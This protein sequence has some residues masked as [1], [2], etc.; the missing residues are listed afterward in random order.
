MAFGMAREGNESEST[1]GHEQ[2]LSEV[3][4]AE[5]QEIAHRKTVSLSSVKPGFK[6][7]LGVRQG[8]KLKPSTRF[9]LLGLALSGG[10]IRSATF[11][12]GVLQ[13]LSSRGILKHVDYLST[14][15]GG[16]YLGSCLSSLLNSPHTEP[17]GD[18]FP[19]R[20][21]PGVEEPKAVK[22]LRNH[23]NYLSSGGLLDTIR[24]PVLLLRGV[25]INLLAVLPYV[26]LT[27]IL[28]GYIYGKPMVKEFDKGKVQLKAAHH[29]EGA[30]SQAVPKND[31]GTNK[32]T[33]FGWK[34]S[35]VV[36]KILCIG[37]FLWLLLFPLVCWLYTILPIDRL[38]G[39]GWNARDWYERSFAFG[40]AVI[41][42]AAI[43][44]SLP[45]AIVSY[46][47]LWEKVR[48]GPKFFQPEIIT[49]TTIVTALLPFLFSGHALSQIS[50]W[51]RTL[52]LYSL[53]LLGPLIFFLLYLRLGAWLIL[54]QSPPYLGD[55]NLELAYFSSK[56]H[57]AV[58][59]L[60]LYNWQFID[61]NLT[62]LHRFY[63]DRLSKAYLFRVDA[64]GEIRPNDDQK[65]STLNTEGTKAPYHLINAAIN[66]QGSQDIN[67]RGRHSAFF[68]FSKHFTGSEKT[69]YCQTHL[70][71]RADPRI[72][73][74]TT[75]AISGAA[76]APNMG[77]ATVKSL[78][79]ILT[80]LNIRLGYWL[81]NPRR[82]SGVLARLLW[83]R[84]GPLY[85]LKELFSNLD[86]HSWH[87]NIS[88][89]GHIENM[90]VYQL[91]RRHCKFIIIGDAEQDSAL[92]FGGLATL[93]RLARIDMGI[94]IEM[95]LSK[96][97][98]SA[99][100][101]SG[102]HCALGTIHYGNG[103]TGQL[104]YLKSSLTGDEKEYLR[105]YR[106]RHPTFPHESTT[107]QFFDE[108]QFEVYRALGY[109][110]ANSLFKG[111]KRGQTIDGG[112]KTQ[113]GKN[114]VERW[115]DSLNTILLPT[116][117]K[118]AATSRG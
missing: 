50:G 44:E 71:E 74:G 116:P 26:I 64:Q 105:A 35:Y 34:Q 82:V 29:Q 23:S 112:Q 32:L 39:G 114:A 1:Q 38:F 11:N 25:M 51:R 18:K 65:L 80:L 2:F 92:T 60:Y 68:I 101:F 16:G 41:L 15:S 83:P 111:W 84:V 110:V 47:L 90:G 103:E 55:I 52:A 6:E 70:M 62:S 37:F 69:G 91:L 10:G 28:T 40:A 21:Q 3:F 12:L 14:V 33:S 86:A 30:K 17:E 24:I 98:R 5:L 63:R 109:H 27:V 118:A 75:M 76:A 57:F 45:L 102:A 7:A 106:A 89:G 46:T 108:E 4:P 79:F 100:G 9:G 104:L 117:A 77:T 22:H 31:A 67:L 78:V 73:L 43:L 20:H 87:V 48:L 95:D 53:G 115:F 66:L 19:F 54:G 85:L 36:T 94:E 81:R 93:M 59:L 13:A 61:I 96:L 56:V 8:R 42:G 49:W 97:R 72:N 99:S 88:D 113:H 107:D 58:F